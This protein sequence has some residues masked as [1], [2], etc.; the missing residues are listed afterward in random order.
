MEMRPVRDLREF[1]HV[2]L[3]INLVSVCS[4]NPTCDQKTDLGR[5]PLHSHGHIL[6]PSPQQPN[7][8]HR[9]HQRFHVRIPHGIQ[10]PQGTSSPPREQSPSNELGTHCRACR[11]MV[12]LATSFFP[13]SVRHSTNC[14]T[15]SI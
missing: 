8:T 10:L 14:L 13:S 5:H 9:S 6:S 12:Q 2:V 4:F 11:S 1:V 3:S 7:P 15:R